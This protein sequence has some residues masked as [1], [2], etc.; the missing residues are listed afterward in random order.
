MKDSVARTKLEYLASQR[1][2]PAEL[3]GF[4]QPHARPISDPKQPW[5]G[6]REAGGKEIV[7]SLAALIA[8][9]NRRVV[10]IWEFAEY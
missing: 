9:D 10:F 4:H 8:V 6:H 2:Y 3:P 1:P 7:R 5:D